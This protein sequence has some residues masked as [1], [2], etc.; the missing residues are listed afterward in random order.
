MQAALHYMRALHMVI[1]V[2]SSCHWWC[3]I[4]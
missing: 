1:H 4:S 2:N 3:Y